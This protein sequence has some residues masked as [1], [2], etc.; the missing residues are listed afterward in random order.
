MKNFKVREFFPVALAVLATV[1]SLTAAAAGPDQAAESLSQA[2]QF[3]TISFQDP[4]QVDQSLFL[5][6]HEFLAKRYPLV[7][8][9]LKKEMVNGLSLLYT[10]EGS[11]PQARSVIL[12][13]HIDVVPIAPGTMADWTYPP[14]SGQIAEG[15]IWGRGTMDDKGSLIAILEAVENLLAQGFEPRRTIYLAFGQDEEVGGAEGA[16][17]M[18]ELLAARGVKAEYVLDESG[19]IIDGKMLGISKPVAVVGIAEKGYL[20]VELKVKTEGGHSSMPPPHTA[21]GILAGAIVRLEN[22]PFPARLEGVPEKTF[23]ALKPELPGYMRFAIGNRWLLSGVIKKMLS[24]IDATNAMIRTTTAATIIAAGTKENV[25]PQ[26]ARAV[27]NF[28]LL[29]GDSVDQVVERVK[30]VID[31]SRVSVEALGTPR[32]ASAITDTNSEGYG[33]VKRTIG[34]LFPEAVVTPLLVLG[35]TDSRFY[36]QVSDCI[37]RFIPMRVSEE[38]QKRAHGTNERVAVDNFQEMVNFYAQVVKNSE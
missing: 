31:D 18:A 16:V 5:A 10:W 38:D 28:R 15:F 6:F 20:S 2:V 7:H 29:P 37:L 19:V 8:Q 27:V 17:K 13:A 36:D 14:F 11:D 3:Q 23:V 9:R 4:A 34:D 24:G 1:M 22:H 12:C 32:E 26:E 25:L 33:I 21:I 30:Q 35:G